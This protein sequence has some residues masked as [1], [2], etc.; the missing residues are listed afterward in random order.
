MRPVLTCVL[1]ALLS[2]PAIATADHHKS[3]SDC[4]AFD[5]QDKGDAGIEMTVH[6]AC[7]IPVDCDVSWK[8][9]CNPDSKKRREI[10]PSA[11][12][13]TLTEGTSQATDASAA[14]CGD[15]AWEINDIEWSCQANKD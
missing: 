4:T 1:A 12:K 11:A 2:I 14:V 8:V 5:Q 13:L 10:H 9:V 7:S 15:G 3:L 6:N